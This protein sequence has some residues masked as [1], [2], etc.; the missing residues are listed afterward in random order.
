MRG[1]DRRNAYYF[2]LILSLAK[3][4]GSTST[5]RGTSCPRRS[6][7]AV[8]YGSGDEQIAFRYLTERGGAVTRKHAF[9]GIVPNLERR[10]QR[11]RIAGGARGT[12]QVHQRAAL[13]RLRRRSA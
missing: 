10:Y 6:R 1:W 5:R 13:P 8:L 11:N 7:Q 12:G 3:H 2:Q 9:E 4:Y